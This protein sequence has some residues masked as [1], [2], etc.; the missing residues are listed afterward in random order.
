MAESLAISE[1]ASKEQ[2]Y[3]EILPQIAALIGTE[4]NITANLANIAAVLTE[5]FNHLWTGFYLRDGESLVLGPFQGPLACTRIPLDPAPKGVCGQSAAQQKTLIVPN[6]DEFP[7]HIACSSLSK[8]EI[9]VP[10]VQDGQTALV[11]DID[12]VELNSFGETDAKYL[13]ALI[14]LIKQKHFA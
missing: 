14:D 7:G 4:E 3:E 12:S 6:V 10:L 8:S 1:G 13:E 5:A 9:V 2:I 11:L